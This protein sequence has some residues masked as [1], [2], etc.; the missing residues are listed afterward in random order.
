MDDIDSLAQEGGERLHAESLNPGN[1][2]PGDGP[3]REVP[4][5]PHRHA[6]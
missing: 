6:V 5:I 4:P 2:E 1:P 3:G